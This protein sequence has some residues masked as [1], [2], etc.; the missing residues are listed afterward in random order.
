MGDMTKN[1]NRSEFAC[2]CGC[3]KNNIDSKPPKLAQKVRD[4]LNMPVRVN[5]GVRCEKRNKAVGGVENSYHVQGLAA[6]LSCK[7]GG[8]TLFLAIVNMC[9]SGELVGAEKPSYVIWYR[10][11]DFV[12]VDFGKKR[13]VRFA[14]K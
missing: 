7:A 6:D 14:V 10:K 9:D 12:H 2:K 5:S 1:F 11:K 3:G 13:S 4:K 8:L